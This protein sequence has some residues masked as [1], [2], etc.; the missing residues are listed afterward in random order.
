MNTA[1][2]QLSTD[3][4]IAF[5]SR[6]HAQADRERRQYNGHP[7]YSIVILTEFELCELEGILVQLREA[8][9]LSDESA[10]K[11]MIGRVVEPAARNLMRNPLIGEGFA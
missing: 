6:L 3:R 10:V 1:K 8:E 11:E 9:I 4:T 5:L 7:P 2:A